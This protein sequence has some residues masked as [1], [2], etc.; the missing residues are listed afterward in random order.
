MPTRFS[1]PALVLFAAFAVMTCGDDDGGKPNRIPAL[2]AV[3]S[4]DGQSEP[5]G[6]LLPVPIV[7]QVTDANGDPV[8]DVP[9]SFAVTKGGGQLSR[10]SA[11]SDQ[12]GRA[13]VLWTLGPGAGTDNNV[14][15]ASVASLG[16]SPATFTAS[17]EAIGVLSTVSGNAQQGGDGSVLTPLVVEA[18]DLGN[19]PIEGLT[20]TWQVL[21]GGGSIAAASSITDAAGRASAM[22]TMGP[23]P[24]QQS[25]RGRNTGLSPGTIRFNATT[26]VAAPSSIT[27]SVTPSSGPYLRSG[28]ARPSFGQAAPGPVFGVEGFRPLARGRTSG[29]PE[30]VANQLV[31]KFKPGA[32]AFP[33]LRAAGSV[34]TAR[35]VARAIRTRLTAYEMAGR[36]RVAGI[37]PVLSSARLVV[38]NPSVRDSMIR[39]LAADPAVEG[40]R[41]ATWLRADGAPGGFTLGPTVVP[42]DPNYPNQSWHYTMIGLPEAWAITTGSRNVIVAVL[43]NGIRFDHPALTANLRN[44]GRDFVPQGQASGVCGG[45]PLDNAADGNGYDADPTIPIDYDFTFTPGGGVCLDSNQPSAFGG[46]GI[47]T[48]GTVGATGNDGISVTG[49]NWQVGIRPVRVLGLTGGVDFDVAQG[50]LYAAGLPADDGNGGVLTPPAIGAHIINMSLGGGCLPPGPDVLHDAIVAATNPTLPHGGTLVVASAGNGNPGTSVPSCPGAYPEVLSVSA[51]GPSGELAF[52]SNFGNT[53]DIAAPGGDLRKTPAALQSVDGTFQVFSTVCD[54]RTVPCTPGQARYE[55]TSMA[56]PHVSGVAALLLAQDPSLTPAQLR[57]RLLTYAVPIGPAVLYGA[58]LVNARN[59]LVQ[60]LEPPHQTIV[61]L[62][63]AATGA[64]IL[65]QPAT[66]GQYSFTGL[67]DGTYFIY[68]GEDESGDNLLGLPGRR[69]GAYGGTGAP[70]PVTVSA[71]TG[72]FASFLFDTPAEHE[73]NNAADATANVLQAGAYITGTLPQSDAAD[74]YRIN[75]AT[76]GVYTLETSGFSGALCSFALEVNTSLRLLAQDGVTPVGTPMD[77]IDPANNNYCSRETVSLAPGTYFVGI[78]AGPFLTTTV[79]HEGRYR[80]QL[81]AGN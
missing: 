81:R 6:S 33:G 3:L 68:A 73:P 4:G 55:G 46:H 14:V 34:S 25:A 75:I 66:G 30:Y 61:Q 29:A 72:A 49:V 67:P 42:N 12:L 56:A 7:A 31:V 65:S 39:V 53:I 70:K 80:L 64:L 24:G 38:S 62:L 2:I 8:S 52:Y 58:G 41:P 57:Q 79:K 15:H 36:V 13:A 32:I 9:V 16:G 40:V 19:V 48:A 43:D 1:R 45:V 74:F 54:F 22:W 21:S 23:G 27:G 26:I 28:G 18:R 20:I 69:W 35:V 11:R 51:V 77:D 50:I 60:N 47:H 5:A 44:D 59:S 17:G 76:G 71:T 10:T 63:D 37:S 78:T